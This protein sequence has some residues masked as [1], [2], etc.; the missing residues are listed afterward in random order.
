MKKLKPEVVNCL[1]PNK[2]VIQT[3]P[4]CTSLNAGPMSLLP[5]D[6]QSDLCLCNFHYHNLRQ[7]LMQLL[8]FLFCEWATFFLKVPFPLKVNKVKIVPTR[9]QKQWLPSPTRVSLLTPPH[10]MTFLSERLAL[11]W[12][13]QKEL[14]VHSQHLSLSLLL[15]S[16]K[17]L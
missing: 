14:M 16:S 2:P 8:L 3:A 9:Y 1:A 5:L 7:A 13:K 10:W 11:P 4:E 6:T 17:S 15:A 12:D